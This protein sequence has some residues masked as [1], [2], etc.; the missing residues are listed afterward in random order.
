[1]GITVVCEKYILQA[2]PKKNARPTKTQQNPKKTQENPQKKTSNSQDSSG[3]HLGIQ[4][5]PKK[6]PGRRRPSTTQENLRTNSIN[7]KKKIHLSIP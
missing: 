7:L 2:K 4:A 6:T 1:M 5:K 3:K